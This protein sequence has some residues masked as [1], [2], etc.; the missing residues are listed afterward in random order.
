MLFVYYALL[1]EVFFGVHWM[2]LVNIKFW[3][4][5]YGNKIMSKTWHRNIAEEIN[6]LPVL[7]PPF[8]SKGYEWPPLHL[9][10]LQA[11]HFFVKQ[12]ALFSYKC[13]SLRQL[14]L[15][16]HV[17]KT[18][19]RKFVISE[20]SKGQDLS[21]GNVFLLIHN[22]QKDIVLKTACNKKHAMYVMSLRLL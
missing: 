2:Q 10:K 4:V 12:L 6:L 1:A 5:A 18:F 19:W 3:L 11:K 7:R 8:P 20:L 21:A 14:Q 13:K 17:L 9:L 15:K 22:V 16:V